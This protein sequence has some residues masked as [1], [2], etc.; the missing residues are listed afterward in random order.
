M[1]LTTQT[2]YRPNEVRIHSKLKHQNV[3]PLLAVLMGEKHG[4]HSEQLYCY[5]FMP[6]MDYD[7]RRIFSAKEVGCL[8]HLHKNSLM[9]FDRAFSN[10]KYM[11]RELLKALAFIHSNGYVH[12]DVKGL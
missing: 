9:N 5:H 11:L 1:V 8:K 7:L 2:V 3:L 12:R 10:V 6:I 4:T